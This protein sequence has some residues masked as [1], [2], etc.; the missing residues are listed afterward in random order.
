MALDMRF[1]PREEIMGDAHHTFRAFIETG[2]I[3]PA[4]TL[5]GSDGMPY[6]PWMY[7]QQEHLLLL[8]ILTTTSSETRG[9]LK[10]FAREYRSFREE[11]CALLVISA[12]TVKVNLETQE[13]LHVPFPLLADPKGEVIARYTLWDAG[14]KVVM[15]S[16]VLAD[17]CGALYRQWAEEREEDL[18]GIE[19]ILEELR[20]LNRLCTP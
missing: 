16:I 13:E 6:S 12:D 2:E 18:V 8:I 9:L 20:Y 4:F 3:I 1:S 10:A 14:Q 11:E 7:K 5:P 17:R 15:P 19:E